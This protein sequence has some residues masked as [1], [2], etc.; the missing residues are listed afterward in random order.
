VGLSPPLR[1]LRDFVPPVPPPQ[2]PMLTV[3][4]IDLAIFF[5]QTFRVTKYKSS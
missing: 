2:L 1:K 4:Y 3:L 5:I